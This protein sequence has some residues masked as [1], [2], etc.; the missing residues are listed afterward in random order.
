MSPAP[1]S[2]PTAIAVKSI[3]FPIDFSSSCDAAAAIV[4]R[5][6]ARHGSVV[7]LTHVLPS[8]EALDGKVEPHDKDL[9][10]KRMLEFVEAHDLGTVRHTTSLE[11]GDVCEI[12][13]AMVQQ[14]DVDLLVMGTHGR[15]GISK[16]VVGSVAEQVFRTVPCPVL[17]VGPHVPARRRTTLN[18]VVL[19]TDFAESSIHSLRRARYFAWED[20]A[21][22]LI[23]HAMDEVGFATYGHADTML[24]RTQ[25]KILKW[26]EEIGGPE[27]RIT[28]IAAFGHAPD[29]ICRVAGAHQSDLIVMGAR[30]FAQAKGTSHTVGATA[31]KVT[32]MAAC[33]V[34]TIKWPHRGEV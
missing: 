29:V 6:A 2:A 15:E 33:P 1:A 10:R 24:L 20:A 34:L 31:Y 21:E 22:L 30:A 27:V 4:R 12:V 32:C 7:H 26:A 19:A 8:P 17:T 13:G 28:P 11:I 14:L 3:L 18:S 9:A 5:L 25:A 23:V 16:L